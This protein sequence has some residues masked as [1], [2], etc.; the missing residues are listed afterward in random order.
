MFLQ[1]VHEHVHI[2]RQPGVELV[3]SVF[4][5]LLV[6][7]LTEVAVTGPM[8][9]AIRTA[10]RREG[11]V[12]PNRKGQSGN[13][14]RCPQYYH[15]T[16]VAHFCIDVLTVIPSTAALHAN[17]FL[18]LF[19]VMDMIGAP[20]RAWACIHVKGNVGHVTNTRARLLIPREKAIPSAP[21]RHRFVAACKEVAIENMGKKS[22][23]NLCLLSPRFDRLAP[24]TSLR[25]ISKW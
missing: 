15:A 16:S 18:T 22:V 11:N 20:F 13:I 4:V 2:Q 14:L 12:G 5:P 17:D 7:Q 21:R 3:E 1:L 10:I 19:R 25:L 6:L 24:P 8:V 9:V 23:L